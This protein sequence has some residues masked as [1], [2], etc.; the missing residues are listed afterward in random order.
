MLIN[1]WEETGVAHCG[2][3]KTTKISRKE[4]LRRSQIFDPVTPEYESDTTNSATKSQ[5]YK[6]RACVYIHLT[7]RRCKVMP[8]RTAIT[9]MKY[10]GWEPN[11]KNSFRSLWLSRIHTTVYGLAPG[12][13]G[14]ALCTAKYVLL[15][16]D[17][18]SFTAYRELYLLLQTSYFKHKWRDMMVHV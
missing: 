18:R 11:L 2:L 7:Y 13:K 4:L 15:I 3:T 12:K 9:R 17:E 8:F 16:M 10:N 6:D 14:V 1:K 5:K